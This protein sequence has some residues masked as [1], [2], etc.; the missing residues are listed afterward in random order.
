MDVHVS[1]RHVLV[2]V[3]SKCKLKTLQFRDFR[4]TSSRSR[5]VQ[6]AVVEVVEAAAT[7]ADRCILYPH[8]WDH[9]D[10][11]VALH[12]QKSVCSIAFPDHCNHN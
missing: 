4:R 7:A 9:V 11:P 2:M 5:F 12:V 10:L 1:Y 8:Y 3:V 6:P